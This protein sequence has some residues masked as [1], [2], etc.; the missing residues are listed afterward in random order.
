MM[1]QFQSTLQKDGRFVILPLPFD[2]KETFSISKGTI[3]VIG[4]INGVAFR[5]KLISKGNNEQI[6]MIDKAM[7]NKLRFIDEPLTVS[8]DMD[9]E[10]KESV[11]PNVVIKTDN[12]VLLNIKNRRS[13]REFMDKRIDK[14]II[15]K[16]IDAGMHAPSAK[17]KQP[18]HYIIIDDKEQLD[19]LGNTNPD[20]KMI[21]KAPCVIV[22]CG[23]SNKEGMKELLIADCTAV[24]QNMLLAIRTLGLG[25][26]W[27]AVLHNKPWYKQLIE[28]LQLPNK[29]EPIAVIA[30][31]FPKK[32]PA[33][34]E[35][36]NTNKIHYKK[37]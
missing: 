20:A 25:G 21:K 24:T 36:W 19:R 2:A 6:I 8:V 5:N 32:I 31:G 7:Q 23:D 14:E 27:C 37:W 12:E 16:I 10:N 3:Y 4:H 29:I 9:V 15:D 1:L 18:C 11:K 30:F 17:N 22:V 26:V 34:V 28:E 33:Q 35:R 13:I